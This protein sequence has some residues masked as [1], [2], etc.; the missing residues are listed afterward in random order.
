M[1]LYQ[2][3][4]RSWDKKDSPPKEFVL[5][6]THFEYMSDALEQKRYYY[7]YYTKAGIN[8][9]VKILSQEFKVED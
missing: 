9:D 2:V 1:K 4:Y 7:N 5:C 8:I 6:R 3:F